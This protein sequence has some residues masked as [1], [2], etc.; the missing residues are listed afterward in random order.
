M[1]P[2]RGGGPPTPRGLLGRQ[3]EAAAAAHLAGLGFR[4]VARNHA[5][6]GGEVDLVA[7]E[8][9]CLCF[10]EVR[11]RRL[12]PIRPAETVSGAKQQ[13]VVRAARDYLAIHGIPSVGARAMRF[14]VVEVTPHPAG[15]LEIVLLR[16][17]FEASE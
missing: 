9:D 12:G 3:G 10:V 17:A 8:G 15:R 16:D 11:T 6:R 13:R 2:R 14:D 7:E 4:I 1:S 5:C